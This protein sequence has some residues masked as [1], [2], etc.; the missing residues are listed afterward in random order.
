MDDSDRKVL[1]EFLSQMDGVGS[2]EGNVLVLAATN[3]PWDLD[4]AILDRLSKQIHVPLP[5]EEARLQMLKI[6]VGDTTNELTEV[7]LQRLAQ[8]TDGASARDVKAL[9]TDALNEP[10]DE[11]QRAN[12]FRQVGDMYT[13]VSGCEHCPQTPSACLQCGAKKMDL[14]GV[15]DD[16]LR[17]RNVRFRDASERLLSQ[18]VS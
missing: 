1:N 14:D 7:D 6:H 12:Y 16:K 8:L 5:D 17:S 10:I 2:G 3:T 9:V 15:P 13:A 11:A 4:D 18:I